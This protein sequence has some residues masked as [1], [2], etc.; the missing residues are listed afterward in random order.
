MENLPIM[1]L[2]FGSAN[3]IASFRILKGNTRISILFEPLWGIPFVLYNFYLSLY[4][5]SYGITD[6]QLGYI[7]FAGFI[8]GSLFSIFGG[9]ITDALGRKK[10]T[11]IFDFIAWPAAVFI[12]FLSSSFWGFLIASVVNQVTRIVA[13]SWNLMLIEDAD[14]D[15]RIAA[16]NLINITSIATGILTPLS[17]ILVRNMGIIP[18]EKTF[19]LVASISMAFMMITRNI[20]YRETRVGQKILEKHQKKSFREIFR[21]MPYKGAFAVIS[22][23]PEIALILGIFVLFNIY[24]PIGTHN[25]LYFAPFMTEVLG[26]DK[27]LVSILGGIN[28]AVML[29]VFIFIIPFISRYNKHFNMIAGLSVQALAL[30][31]LVLLPEK[32]LLLT[33]VCIIIYAE[34]F[35]IFRPFIDAIFAEATEGEERAEIYSFY[36]TLTSVFSAFVGLSS[37]YLYVYNPRSLYIVSIAI[38]ALCVFLIRYY[39]D[40]TYKQICELIGRLTLTRISELNEIGLGLIEKD[41]RYKNIMNSFM[42]YMAA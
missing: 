25:S 13:V 3:I 20:F 10:T 31:L 11:L 26:I 14:N 4:M 15:Q 40:F 39:C 24:L 33:S 34:G 35:G 12:Y 7:I 29:L 1:S 9:V 2:N 28:A 5:K 41:E 27:S 36:H 17:G 8:A 30:L 23:K 32:R 22:K 16:F 18:A 38:L 6:K 19:L 42:E 21:V 37:G